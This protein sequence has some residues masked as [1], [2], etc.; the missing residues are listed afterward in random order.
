VLHYFDDD[1]VVIPSAENDEKYLDT[2]VYRIGMKQTNSDKQIYQPG[3]SVTQTGLRIA[4]VLGALINFSM[5][6][7]VAK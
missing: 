6:L 7:N 1:S 5:L 4:S 3:G 2:S